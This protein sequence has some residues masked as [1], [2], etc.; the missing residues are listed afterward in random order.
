MTPKWAEAIALDPAVQG[1]KPVIRG[2]R[3]PVEVLVSAVG[4]G[5][6]I[7]EVAQQYRVSEAQV[8]AAISYAAELV[9]S[10]RA[11]ALPG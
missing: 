8:R 1:G 2:T 11:L 9:R 7:G 5:D 10:E 3:V 6:D 4:S